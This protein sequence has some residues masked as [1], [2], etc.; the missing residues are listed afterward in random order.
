MRGHVCATMAQ[1]VGPIAVAH[2][3]PRLQRTALTHPCTSYRRYKKGPE[4]PSEV[5]I[6]ILRRAFSDDSEAA[7]A[8]WQLQGRGEGG[9]RP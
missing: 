5:L 3:G 1:S 9:G 7:T 4:I 2:H 8:H 6:L